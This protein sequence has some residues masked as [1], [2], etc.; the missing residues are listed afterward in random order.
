[1]NDGTGLCLIYG[2]SCHCCFCLSLARKYAWAN[3]AV[4]EGSFE[5]GQRQGHGYVSL[6]AMFC[7]CRMYSHY[8]FLSS[9][10]YT[11][12]DGAIYVGEFHQG[13]YQGHGYVR[14]LN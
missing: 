4:Y 10:K 1:M 7:V 3:G 9:S 2:S 14:L 6:L 13:L 8:S 12:P 5:H 11:Y